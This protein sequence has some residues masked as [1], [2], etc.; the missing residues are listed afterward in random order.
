MTQFPE[1]LAKSFLTYTS[2]L[3]L[4]QIQYYLNVLRLDIK[5]ARPINKK[6]SVANIA[7]E[8]FPVNNQNFYYCQSF[9]GGLTK[10]KAS[11]NPITAKTAV[12]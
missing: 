5:P 10:T 4:R 11:T 9:L 1:P 8:A 2:L 3:F 7:K 6:A 12:G